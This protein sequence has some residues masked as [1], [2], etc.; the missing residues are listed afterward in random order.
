MEAKV[1]YAIVGGFVLVLGVAFIAG[2]LWLSSGGASRKSY[3]TYRAYMKE[4]VSG[5]SLDAPVRYRGVEVGRVRKIEL[6]Y[7]D[8]E[9]VQLTMD[10]ERG[11]PVKVD[12]VA[13]LRVQGLTGIAYV[14]LSGGRR[15]SPPLEA[16]P[17]Q[18]YPVISTGPSLMVRLDATLTTLLRNLTRTSENLNAVMDEDNRRAFKR[19]LTDLEMLTRSVA[20]RSGSIDAAIGNAART[21]DNTARVAAEMPQLIDRVQR[22]AEAFEKMSNEVAGAGAS[23]TRTLEAT[24]SDVRQFTAE[25]L[26]EVRQLLSEVRE[27]TNSLRQVTDQVEQNPSVLLFGKPTGKRGPGE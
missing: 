6:A 12:T 26:P 27:L 15:D 9:Q 21:F 7:D 17:E 8:V 2:V 16:L 24:R 10:I 13:I 3:D 5:L 11:T 4:S 14:E 22:S 25:T 19:A 18:P 1:N 20:A 23:A